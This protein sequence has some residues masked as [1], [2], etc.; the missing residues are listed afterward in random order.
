[1]IFNLIV[2]IIRQFLHQKP[3]VETVKKRVFFKEKGLPES[4]RP[5][6][7]GRGDLQIFIA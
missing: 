1:M 7:L 6:I 2:L 3:W 4:G 5:L